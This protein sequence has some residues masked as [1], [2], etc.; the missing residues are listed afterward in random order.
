MGSVFGAN[1]DKIQPGIPV[2]PALQPD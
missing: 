1:G 2:I